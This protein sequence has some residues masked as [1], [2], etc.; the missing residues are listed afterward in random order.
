MMVCGGR[1]LLRALRRL[2]AACSSGP[3]TPASSP[4]PSPTEANTITQYPCPSIPRR[5]RKA[6]TFLLP[7][8]FVNWYP[9][10]YL[11]GRSDP[12]DLPHVAAVLLA[13]RRR[14]SCS[15]VRCSPGAPAYATTRR[16][17]AE[18]ALIEVERPRPHLRGEASDGRPTAYDDRGAG[19]ARPRPSRSRR[20]RWSATSGRT[21][22]ASRPRSRCSP[23]SWC[24]TAGRVRVAGLDPS[25]QRTEL[26]LRIGVVFGQR[27]TLWW[28]LPLR[29]SFDLLQKLYRVDPGA[30]PP[31]PRRVR[32]AARPRRPPR[33]PGPAAQPRAA[34][35]RRHHRGPPPR[36]GDPLPRRAD[37]RP[38]RGQQGPPARLPAHPQRRARHHAPAD[39]PRPAGHRGAVQP[40]DRHRPRHGGLRRPAHRPAPARAARPAP[41]SSTWSTRRR[42]SRSRGR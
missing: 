35:A 40:G 9:C 37:D 25:R 31:Q 8:A 14:S 18:M 5:S 23:A 22:P 41:W 33:H 3:P 16:R 20:A 30:T 39:H 11:L 19:R 38:R 13:R 2:L 1:H 42:R 36:P 6:L 28:D 21:A 15:V 4:T 10:L 12:F 29:D 7:I 24:P 32:R 17:G 26:A 27:T 34:D